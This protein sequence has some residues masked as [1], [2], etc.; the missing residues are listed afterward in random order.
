MIDL[1]VLEF[2]DLLCITGMGIHAF[3]AI[4]AHLPGR[5]PGRY[6]V[7]CETTQFVKEFI[8]GYLAETR[9]WSRVTRS[10]KAKRHRPDCPVG[11]RKWHRRD[12]NDT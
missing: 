12:R 11:C 10:Q 3:K 6:T 9:R 5:I 1:A 4:S 7:A 8:F 2:V